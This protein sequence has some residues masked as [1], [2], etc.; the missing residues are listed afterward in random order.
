MNVWVYV[1]RLFQ[2]MKQEIMFKIGDMIHVI[3]TMAM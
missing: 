1:S 2:I 3:Q